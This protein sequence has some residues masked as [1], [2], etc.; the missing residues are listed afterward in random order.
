MLFASTTSEDD[1]KLFKFHL[2]RRNELI[3]THAANK[4]LKPRL[5]D[6]FEFQVDYQTDYEWTHSNLHKSAR[7]SYH[8]AKDTIHHYIE[9]TRA[10]SYL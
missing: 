9:L 8:S 1:V 7:K 10:R 3:A 4:G 5:I 6:L 2:E